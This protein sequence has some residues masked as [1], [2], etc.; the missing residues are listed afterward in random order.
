LQALTEQFTESCE[1]PQK[2]RP[3]RWTGDFRA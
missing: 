3:S 1:V 2:N